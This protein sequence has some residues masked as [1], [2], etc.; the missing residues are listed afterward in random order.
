MYKNLHNFMEMAAVQ[1]AKIDPQFPLRIKSYA[2]KRPCLGVG[3]TTLLVHKDVC[4]MKDR[5]VDICDARRILNNRR[6]E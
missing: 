5:L 1:Q 4:S 2:R 3:S 6:Q